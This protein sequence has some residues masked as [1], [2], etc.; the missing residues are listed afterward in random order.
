MDSKGVKIESAG[1]FS[2]DAKGKVQ[3]KG[4]AVDVQ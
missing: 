2:I 1:D 4:S 3:I